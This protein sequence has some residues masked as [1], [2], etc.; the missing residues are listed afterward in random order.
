MSIPT[1]P[2][3]L[4]RQS[5]HSLE[6]A[7]RRYKRETE[8]VVRKTVSDAYVAGRVK[9]ARSLIRKLREDP[10]SPRPWSS[11]MDKVG[12]RVICSTTRDCEAVDAALQVR[13]RL[14]ERKVKSGKY[15]RLFYPGTHLIVQNDAVVDP[16]GELIPCEV[17]VRTRAQ[18]AW[19]VVSHKL[20]YKGVIK[21]PRK[22]KRVIQRLTVVVEM[23]DDDVRRMFKRRRQLPMY[24]AAVALETTEDQYEKITGEP[25]DG[26]SDLSLI[27]V[28]LNAYDATERDQY[29]A[30]ID[31]YCSSNRRALKTLI[32]EHQPTQDV[33]VDTRDW[34]F[35]QPEVIS[36]LERAQAKPYMLANAVR[37]TD[38]EDVVRRTCVSAGTPLPES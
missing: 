26:M 34:L 37:D 28:L 25:N 3:A 20:L 10:A 36:V 15:D 27:N 31:R 14:L 13:W 17:Q 32:A 16:F 5:E 2:G 19:A 18:D 22:M 9:T 23:F 21:P 29:P 1:D 24:A 33:Y 7:L 4:Y 12:V 8:R 38:L 35:T 30:I 6:L 11:I